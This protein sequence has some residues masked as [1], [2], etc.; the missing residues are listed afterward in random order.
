MPQPQNPNAKQYTDYGFPT[1]LDVLPDAIKQNSVREALELHKDALV[2][3]IVKKQHFSHQV[4]SIGSG[5][6][7]NSND[8]TYVLLVTAKHVVEDFKKFGFGWVTIG[9]KMIPIDEKIGALKLDPKRDLAYWYIPSEHFLQFSISGLEALPM[10]SSPSIE[11][12]FDP[13][14]SFAL[15]G[16]PWS[17]NKSL[18][19]REDGDKERKL[20]GLALHGYTYDSTTDELCFYYAGKGTPENWSNSLTNPPNLD[21]MSG[22]PCFRFVISRDL[23]RPTVVVAGVFSRW[24]GSHEIRAVS[25]SNAWHRQDAP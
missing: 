9:S 3:F 12:N 21:G 8:P 16:Y 11:E 10:F 15:F 13:T 5:F 20:F 1:L 6:I 24:N 4:A 14:C 23:Y 19:M 18:D 17:K 25:L 22:C 2:S 7:V